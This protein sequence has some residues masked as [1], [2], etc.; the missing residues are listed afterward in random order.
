MGGSFDHNKISLKQLN[1]AKAGRGT[2]L[3]HMSFYILMLHI[4]ETAVPIIIYLNI[5]V[6]IMLDLPIFVQYQNLF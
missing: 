4:S 3:I 2:I 5:I 1:V 6:D